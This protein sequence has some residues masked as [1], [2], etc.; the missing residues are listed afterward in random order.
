MH[1]KPKVLAV[2]GPTASGK[3]ALSIELAK[4][5]DG[6]VISADSRQVYRGLDIGTGKVTAAEMDGVPHHLLDV[7][8][9][10]ETYTAADWQCDATA[11]IE[12]ILNRG[13]RP[14]IAGGTF[15]WLDLLRGKAGTAP[16]EPDET[17]RE[18]LE[19][20]STEELFAELQTKDPAR[21][22]T[23][24]PS[25]RRRLIRALEIVEALGS[26]PASTS[27]E[28]PYDWLVIGMD[29]PKETLQQNFSERIDSWLRAGFQAEVE[30][31]LA[32]GVPRE[33]FQELGF[34]Y[35]LMLDYIDQ[36]ISLTE[37]KE[38]FVQK[39]WQYAKR[40]LTWLKRD[41]EIEWY[42]PENRCAIFRRTDT[43][44]AA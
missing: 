23:I 4:K 12:D 26:V 1:T 44:L 32:D 18:T 31:L 19:Q 39:N 21:A 37:L 24:D 2:V 8:D 28:S 42:A 33:R 10:R 38:K 35:T 9:P 3:T 16:V 30:R 14:I 11:A 7:A 43:F 41:E 20:Q 29:V 15:F 17:L 5:Y 6:E 27:T 34:E 40:Q 13:R 22:A 25:N 36:T